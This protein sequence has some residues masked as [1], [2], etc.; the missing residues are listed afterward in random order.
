MVVGGIVDL[1]VDERY[2]VAARRAG[3]AGSELL[4]SAHGGA[5]LVS[6]ISVRRLPARHTR[7]PHR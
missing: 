6:E 1:C 2:T 3:P 5:A 7:V 4:L